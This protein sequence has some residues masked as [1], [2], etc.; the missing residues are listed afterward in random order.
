MRNMYKSKRG[1]RRGCRGY[2]A[3]VPYLLYINTNLNT[4]QPVFVRAGEFSGPGQSQKQVE[5]DE[6]CFLPWTSVAP[7]SHISK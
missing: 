7:D 5:A 3:R 6:T 1:G 4:G 2:A